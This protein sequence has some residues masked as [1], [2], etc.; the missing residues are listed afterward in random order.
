MHSLYRFFVLILLVGSITTALLPLNSASALSASEY[1]KLKQGQVVVDSKSGQSQGGV[2]A[3]VLIKRPISEVYR[4]IRDSEGLF[5][6]DPTI[7][8]VKLVKRVNSNTEHLRYKLQLSPV[9]PAFDYTNRVTYTPNKS[10][11]FKKIQGSFK[12][13]EGACVL[14]PTSKPDE[15]LMVYSLNLELDAPVPSVVVNHFLASD[16]PKSLKRIERKV[17]QTYP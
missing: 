16:L 17:Y 10:F 6:N 8:D 15:T 11:H 4:V 9:L 13:M 5:K 12:R 1:Q 7:K 2:E 14:K 3:K